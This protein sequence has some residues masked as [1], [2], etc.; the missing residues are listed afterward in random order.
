[1][2]CNAPAP[3]GMWNAMEWGMKLAHATPNIDTSDLE[4]ITAVSKDR[5]QRALEQLYRRHRDLLRSV[6]SRVMSN[7]SDAD[8]VLQD[9]FIQVWNQAGSYSEEKGHLLGWLITLARRRALDRVRQM[10]AYKRATDRYET[11]FDRAKPQVS[12]LYIVEREVCQNEL[13]QQIENHMRNLPEAQRQA[14]NLTFFQG[15][16]QREIAARL[17]IPLGTIKTRLELGMRKL[18]RSLVCERAA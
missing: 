3:V 7:D 2:S 16:T 11:T 6:I 1:M 8:D 5:S 4:L 15:L 13:K 14:V 12:E 10:C 18:G 17:S 9:V